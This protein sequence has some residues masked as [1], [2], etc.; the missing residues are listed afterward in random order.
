MIDRRRTA[1]DVHRRRRR[2]RRDRGAALVEFAIVMPVL[3]LLLFGI[4]DF[5]MQYANMNAVRQ[6]TRDG[7]R[8]A[9]VANF[10]TTNV[11]SLDGVTDTSK[12][13]AYLICL[14]KTRVG[15]PNASTRV[16]VRFTSSN[17]VGNSVL[18]CSMY[19][20]S[21]VSGMFTPLFTGRV[22]KTKVEMRIEQVDQ[23]LADTAENPLTGQSWSWCA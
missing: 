14:T 12:P 18:V 10:G 9:V 20:M 4:T 5:G 22:L 1:P 8:Q 15:L 6:G 11:C 19:P 7:A 3:F 13:G 17:N 23:N 21:S 2:T 16:K